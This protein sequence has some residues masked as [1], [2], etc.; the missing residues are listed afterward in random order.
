MFLS[1]AKLAI[2]KNL[3]SIVTDKN[4]LSVNNNKTIN[5]NN[6]QS[7]NFCSC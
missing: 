5:N 1:V 7:N 2:E 4:S 6:K 3:C